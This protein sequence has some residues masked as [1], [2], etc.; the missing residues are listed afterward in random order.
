MLVLGEVGW[1]PNLHP[2]RLSPNEQVTHMTLWS[3]LAAPLLIGC[4]LRK[5]DDFTLALL[6]N[7]EVIEINQDSLGRPAQRIAVNGKCEVWARP[8]SNGDTAVGLF[9]R[10]RRAATVRVSW[11]QLGRDGPQRVRDVWQRAPLD[12][13]PHRCEAHVPAHGALLLRIGSP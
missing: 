5:L 9:N 8:L 12:S 7:P 10:G 6:G 4:D 3:L 1:G 2:T 13:N 11:S